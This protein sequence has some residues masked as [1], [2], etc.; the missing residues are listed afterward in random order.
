MVKCSICKNEGHSAST[1]DGEQITEWTEKIKRFWVHG[2]N[3]SAENDEAVK[4]WVQNQRFKM[5]L[6]NRLWRKFHSEVYCAKKWYHIPQA[7]RERYAETRFYSPQPKTV[8]EFRHRI[9][10]YVRPAEPEI[11]MVRIETELAEARREERRLRD[12]RIQERQAAEEARLLAQRER[13][14]ANPNLIVQRNIQRHFE[15][16]QRQ[17]QANQRQ[18]NF[19]NEQMVRAHNQAMRAFIPTK[20]PS[21]PT[22]MD[23]LETEY[24]INADCP[25]CLEPQMPGNTIALGCRHTC[26]V[27]CLKQAMKPGGKHCCVICR[28]TITQIRFKPD[29]TPDNFNIISKHIHSLG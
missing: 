28:N 5:P 19:Q 12:Q 27:S 1:C 26:C 9:L 22:Q 6:V 15:E 16:Q 7:N 21:I 2:R 23:S 29:I 25:I 14:A 18:A 13:D 10:N 11:D 4:H 17:F 24:F 3:N 20:P 8:E